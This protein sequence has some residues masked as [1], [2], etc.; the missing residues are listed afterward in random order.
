MEEDKALSLLFVGL[1][2]TA[3]ERAPLDEYSDSHEG[4][5]GKVIECSTRVVNGR[6]RERFRSSLESLEWWTLRVESWEGGVS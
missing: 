5:L 2:V 6:E 1:R 3:W 4:E